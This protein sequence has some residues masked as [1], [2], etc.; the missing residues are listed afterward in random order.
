MSG[1]SE[2]PPTYYFSGIKF[3]PS[4]YQSSSSD[5]LTLATAKSSFLTYPKAQGSE[6]ISTLISSNI[7]SSTINPISDASSFSIVPSQYDGILNI[8]TGERSLLGAINI[9]TGSINIAN[10]I[11][12][13][14]TMSAVNLYG[15]VTMKSN[16]LIAAGVSIYCGSFLSSSA[17]TACTFASN[18]SSA[19]ITVGQ[20]QLSGGIEIANNIAFNGTV[21]IAG[22]ATS[23]SNYI[24]LGNT[25]TTITAAGS[26]IASQGLTFPST[27]YTTLTGQ[28]GYMA[29][30]NGSNNTPNITL[31]ISLVGTTSTVVLRVT[32]LPIGY[33]MATVTISINTATSPGDTISVTDSVSGL[34]SYIN[35]VRFA[36]PI[37]GGSAIRSAGVFSGGIKITSLTSS[38]VVNVATQTGTVTVF[39]SS[40]SYV[41]IA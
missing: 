7:Y 18:V 12:I 14:S 17:S 30:I 16:N 22:S 19:L 27:T 21:A 8:G 32:N 4:F 36:G 15:T 33:Y 13:G 2:I 34:T 23:G 37:V 20:G 40:F 41:R 1:D 38:Y 31:P 11:T 10:P 26:L 5:Y 24:Q 9:G 35:L 28:L 3:N 29:I 39:D 6:T 25:R